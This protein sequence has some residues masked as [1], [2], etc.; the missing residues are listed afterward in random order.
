[1]YAVDDR[2]RRHAM[3]RRELRTPRPDC[4]VG[5]KS[6]CE[7]RRTSGGTNLVK[8]SQVEL[9]GRQVRRSESERMFGEEL[10]RSRD[11]RRK[12][13]LGERKGSKW[14]FRVKGRV[15]KKLKN[16]IWG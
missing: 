10:L 11:G 4:A 16:V 9:Q 6:R 14:S 1:M 2:P 13:S 15:P 12:G 7:Q 5:G 3:Q 8:R